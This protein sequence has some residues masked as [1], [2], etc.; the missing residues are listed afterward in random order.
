M[1]DRVTVRNMSQS[2]CP[3]GVF[4]LTSDS[5]KTKEIPATN[6]RTPRYFNSQVPHLVVPRPPVWLVRPPAPV[7]GGLGPLGLVPGVAG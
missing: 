5:T 3:E 6:N 4:Y 7:R 1:E 2:E